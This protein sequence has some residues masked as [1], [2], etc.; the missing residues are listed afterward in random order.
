MQL[1]FRTGAWV[2]PITTAMTFALLAVSDAHATVLQAPAD[3]PVWA[4]IG[5]AALLSM[6]IIGGGAGIA[7]GAIAIAT[8]KG[9]KVHRAVGR[10]F[11]CVMLICYTVAAGVAPF[12]D[13][14]QRPNTIAGVMALYLLLTGWTAAQ[15]PEIRSGV[16]QV[17][18]LI[19]ALTIAGAGALFMKM[20][21]D[22]TTGTIDG[23]PPEAFVVFMAAGLFAAAG[24]L[25]VLVRR[26]LSGPA[27]IARHLWRMCFSLFIASG[28]FFLGQMQVMPQWM[29]ES[30]L[31]YVA[32]LAPLGAML[33]WLVLV[34]IPKR[35]KVVPAPT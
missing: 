29:R 8:R 33:V 31:P 22:S 12:L 27:R 6:H 17:A 5:A 4:H 24:E 20:G 35:R 7:T 10:V 3:A 1:P 19:T 2:W 18:G 21:A 9:G 28:S 16:Y 13:D 25:H 23:S 11:F 32:A 14:G 34:R 26:T 15:R 30:A